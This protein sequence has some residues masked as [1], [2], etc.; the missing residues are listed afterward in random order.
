MQSADIK[1]EILEILAEISKERYLRIEMAT[2]TAL[3]GIKSRA[4]IS[5]LKSIQNHSIYGRMLRKALEAADKVQ[6]SLA[7]GESLAGVQETI[8]KLTEQNQKL[9][10]KLEEV[11]G[12]GGS[13]EE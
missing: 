3:S 13:A 6:R 12:R 11:L 4:S 8:D 5:L 2:I 9:N 10:S 1:S 7:E